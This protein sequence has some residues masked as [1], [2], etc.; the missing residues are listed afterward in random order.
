MDKN[1]R[2]ELIGRVNDTLED[3]KALDCELANTGAI[4]E[5]KKMLTE[6][7]FT[8]NL[9]ALEDSLCKLEDFSSELWRLDSSELEVLDDAL[10]YIGGDMDITRHPKDYIRDFEDGCGYIHMSKEDY[11]RDILDYKVVN[12]EITEE[13]VDCIDLE[14]FGRGFD[15]TELTHGI[16]TY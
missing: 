13:L 10:E 14:M 11:L 9:E 16:T 1:Y 5:L 8:E 4:E 2:T 6:A 3:L 12:G 15:I 7:Y